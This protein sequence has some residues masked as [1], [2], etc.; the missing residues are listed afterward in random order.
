MINLEFRYL[1]SKVK[2]YVNDLSVGHWYW[3]DRTEL[4]SIEE[5]GE[6]TKHTVDIWHTKG[7]YKFINSFNKQKVFIISVAKFDFETG[8]ISSPK[9]YGSSNMRDVNFDFETDYVRIEAIII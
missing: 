4:Y 8:E 1:T 7:L 2:V 5:N 9:V 3:T 6:H